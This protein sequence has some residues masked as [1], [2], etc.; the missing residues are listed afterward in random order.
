MP[1]NGRCA[2][3]E[4]LAISIAATRRYGVAGIA[5]VRFSDGAV[6]SLRI[7]HGCESVT[8]ETRL[9]PARS[10]AAMTLATLP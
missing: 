8:T 6:V 5:S 10:I 2:V 7:G 3:K 1:R 9:M 4:S